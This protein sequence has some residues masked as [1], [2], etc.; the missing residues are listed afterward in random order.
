[1]SVKTKKSCCP[2]CETALDGATALQGKEIPNVGD[3][4]VCIYCHEL[5]EFD[6]DL[7]LIKCDI[8]SLDQDM[9][10]HLVTVLVQIASFKPTLH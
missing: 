4:S 8:N 1:M 2:T 7:M 9:Q 10:D 6:K 5:L 3:V